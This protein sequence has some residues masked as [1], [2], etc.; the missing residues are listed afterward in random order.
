M[1][2][3]VL[4]PLSPFVNLIEKFSWKGGCWCSSPG[5]ASLGG[6]DDGGEGGIA[7]KFLEATNVACQEITPEYCEGWIRHVKRFLPKVTQGKTSCVKL[8]R[9]CGPIQKTKQIRVFYFF[10][11]VFFFFF[12]MCIHT[13]GKVL[14]YCGIVVLSL[15][16]KPLQKIIAI[17]QCVDTQNKVKKMTCIEK[18]DPNLLS[19]LHWA[20]WPHQNHSGCLPC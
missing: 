19:L 5:K 1:V 20:T 16:I 15:K 3:L 18:K 4:S 14:F 2:S 8:M 13:L 9:S 7:L 17:R 6:G 11:Q 12:I 10:I